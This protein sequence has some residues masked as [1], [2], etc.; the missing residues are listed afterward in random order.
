ML[1]LGL[2]P[3]AVHGLLV[4]LRGA[5]VTPVVDT[6]EAPPQ[7]SM[8]RETPRRRSLSMRAACGPGAGHGVRAV[9]TSPGLSPQET[10]DVV[11]A[12]T[13]MG[14]WVGERA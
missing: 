7:L 3:R 13:A 6:R 2:G 10:Q 1:V 9:F 12:A 4:V 8:L 5:A 11:N 14:L